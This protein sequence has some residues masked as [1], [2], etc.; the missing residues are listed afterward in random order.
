MI[1]D[2]KGLENPEMNG[3]GELAVPLLKDYLSVCLGCR[4]VV[5]KGK[6]ELQRMGGGCWRLCNG[7][8]LSPLHGDSL[9]GVAGLSSE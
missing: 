2:W 1:N 5:F 3:L 8:L 9:P 7:G 6:A 4:Y